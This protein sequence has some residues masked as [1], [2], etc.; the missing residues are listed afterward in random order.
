MK[1]LPLQPHTACE[2]SSGIDPQSVWISG[3][4]R[5]RERHGHRGGFGL[6][7][8]SACLR[9][10]FVPALIRPRRR[11]RARQ[12]SQLLTE[13]LG[14]ARQG[15]ELPDDLEGFS[16]RW[17]VAMIGHDSPCVLPVVSNVFAR[18]AGNATAAT[19]VGPDIRLRVVDVMPQPFCVTQTLVNLVNQRP[20]LVVHLPF[21]H[22]NL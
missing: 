10:L 6:A 14:L 7:R 2:R 15:L 9:H 3:D 12:L 21:R 18:S 8:G 4:D 17:H 16:R 19:A 11:L 13:S 5:S 1:W 20:R 22:R